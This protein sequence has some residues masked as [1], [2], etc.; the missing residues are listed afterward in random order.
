MNGDIT[1]NS[2]Q[3]YDDLPEELKSTSDPMLLDRTDNSPNS[4]VELISDDEDTESEDE[5]FFMGG[6]EDIGELNID[7]C[8]NKLIDLPPVGNDI[9][10]KINGIVPRREREDWSQSKLYGIEG[11]I[12]EV[13][14][15]GVISCVTFY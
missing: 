12:W 6:L 4:S 13:T 8:I 7:K 9:D 3:Y 14:K 15:N 10:Y 5:D 1:A 11:I 2:E